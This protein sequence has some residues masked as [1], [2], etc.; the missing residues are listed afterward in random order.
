[1]KLLTL[2]FL[3]TLFYS[4]AD[5]EKAKENLCLSITCSGHGQCISNHSKNIPECK[6]DDGYL[7]IGAECI[8]DCSTIKNSTPNFY[9]TACVCNPGYEDVLTEDVLTS[10]NKSICD[11]GYIN[12]EG[13]CT[14]DCRNIANSHPTANSCECDDG[15]E[16]IDESC[17]FICDP[18]NNLKVNSKN[19][20]CICK[21]DFFETKVENVCADPCATVECSENKTCKGLSFDNAI[22]EC[23]YGFT[24]STEGSKKLTD[25]NR[26]DRE[27]KLYPLENGNYVMVWTKNELL[28]QEDNTTV[29]NTYIK[30]IDSNGVNVQLRKIGNSTANRIEPTLA[31]GS[32]NMVLVWRDKRNTLDNTSYGDDIYL[33]VLSFTGELIGGE[34]RVTSE[35]I[36]VLNRAFSPKIIWNAANSTYAI[37][38]QEIL[39]NVKVINYSIFSSN[40]IISLQATTVT[41][42]EKNSFDFDVTLTEDN[43]YAM[44]WTSYGLSSYRYLNFQILNSDIGT[45]NSSGV[46]KLAPRRVI[47]QHTNTDLP[48][49]LKEDDHYDIFYKNNGKL[50]LTKMDLVGNNIFKEVQASNQSNITTYNVIPHDNDYNV[51]LNSNNRIYSSQLD[52]NAKYKTNVMLV[53]YG[54]AQDVFAVDNLMIW[55]D[56]REDN[57]DIYFDKVGC[58]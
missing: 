51:I 38:W 50:F 47:Y 40:N 16:K 22:C 8:V 43:N 39:D 3:F 19:D 11:A 10:C 17:V 23:S 9:N 57:Y 36:G 28:N 5:V 6:C 52:K 15:Y 25:D 20:G 58:Y 32:S 21:D 56:S 46:V 13:V 42:V 14:Y 31:V 4:C 33:Q 1:M 27:M 49:I 53:P 24:L 35:K 45:I 12:L 29:D 54:F 48:R 41:D 30:I 2:L 7:S 34:T 37:F 26:N 18:E 44:V 55:R